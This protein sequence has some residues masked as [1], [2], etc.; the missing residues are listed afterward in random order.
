MRL[1]AV[2]MIALLIRP[3]AGA[4]SAEGPLV[5]DDDRIDCPDAQ[6]TSIQSA[7]AAADRGSTVLVCKGTYPETVTITTDGVSIKALGPD[8]ALDGGGTRHTG[9][10]LLANSSTHNGL[11]GIGIKDHPGTP[12][13]AH[14]VIEQNQLLANAEHDCHDETFG[15]GTAGTA[16]TWVGNHAETEN[17]LALCRRLS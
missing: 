1:L 17:R 4:A 3:L 14:N 16:N 8:V 9:I 12:L 15:S 7:V 2:S 11:D 13:S 6:H 5:V 10:L